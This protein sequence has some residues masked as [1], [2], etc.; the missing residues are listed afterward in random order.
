[1][2]PQKIDTD[3]RQ[4]EINLG[5]GKL[6]DD[7][8]TWQRG[9]VT[10]GEN[11]SKRCKESGVFAKMNSEI[12]KLRQQFNP[13]YTTQASLDKQTK[14]LQGRVEWMFNTVGP[15]SWVGKKKPRP[16]Y[17]DPDYPLDFGS[18]SDR[19]MYVIVAEFSGI[20][21]RLTITVP[22]R[23]FETSFTRK[24]ALP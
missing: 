22:R 3:T 1:M 12:E 6:A 8:V 17:I 23:T 15:T 11:P 2:V 10:L 14:Y 16:W 20:K 19:G 5:F 21:Q 7:G 9:L 13:A 24:S 4:L 18:E